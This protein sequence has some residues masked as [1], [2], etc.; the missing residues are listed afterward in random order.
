MEREQQTTFNL[1][2]YDA[3]T[4]RWQT[5][6]T[7]WNKQKQRLQV[8][9]IDNRFF[10]YDRPSNGIRLYNNNIIA[11]NVVEYDGGDFVSR[12]GETAT[13]MLFE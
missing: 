8:K 7:V 11:G 3:M 9:A 1:Y 4:F 10:T 6:E 13:T 2:G 5:M 12:G